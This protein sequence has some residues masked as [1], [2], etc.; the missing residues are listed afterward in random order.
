MANNHTPNAR[1]RRKDGR[2]LRKI[3]IHSRHSC[4]S[5]SLRTIWTRSCL[6][7]SPS[8]DR[9]LGQNMKGCRKKAQNIRSH[10]TVAN[11][12]EESKIGRKTVANKMAQ[13]SKRVE[14]RLGLLRG[15]FDKT[16]GG[17]RACM[18]VGR[19]Q[20]G[21]RIVRRQEGRR[22]RV[23]DIGRRLAEGCRLEGRS[24]P[25]DCRIAGRMEA[26]K[27]GR[28]RAHMI[29]SWG[30]NFADKMDDKMARTMGHSWGCNF[31]GRIVR[32]MEAGRTARIA[33]DN[34]SGLLP[35]YLV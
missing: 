24:M 18:R 28:M 26:D 9:N 31:A 33:V 16:G 20:E 8:L 25:E 21:C 35:P 10:T 7:H 2:S 5:G 22:R 27:T 4:P 23:V 17:R 29:G 3:W 1:S 12:W 34:R 30:C 15:N 13:V 6:L 32:S 14:S 11:N 19:R